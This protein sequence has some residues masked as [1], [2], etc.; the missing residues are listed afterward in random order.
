MLRPRPGT[1]P[2]RLRRPAALFTILAMLVALVTGCGLLG[3]EDDSSSSGGQ[4]EKSKIKLGLLPVVDVASVHLAIREG[5]FKAEGLDVE[6]TNIQ[7]AG[8][9]IPGLIG[10]SLDMVFGNYVSFFAA[11]SGGAAK[12]VDGLKFVADGYIA[13]PNTWMVL[14]GPNSSVNTVRDL[15]GKKVAVTT[16]K[17]LAE[18]SIKSVLRANDVDASKVEFIESPYAGMAA[19]MQQNKVDAALLAEPFITQA[20]KSI[21][22]VPLFDAASGPTADLP[23]AGYGTTGKFAKD[24][25]KTVAAFQRAFAKGQLAAGADRNKIEKLLPEY[26][27]IDPQTAALVALGG[28]PTSL[29][30]TRLQRIPDLMLEFGLLP[31]RF[32][33]SSMILNAGSTK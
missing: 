19:L 30:A 22:A 24:N 11:E 7:G 27:G 14:R 1:P 8:A 28:F 29:E 6:L 21:G 3:G 16:R 32:D 25:P 10:G 9:A 26:A 31:N 18:V 20:Q 12:N 23:I 5:Y 13:K 15:A 2:A 17:S 4:V 33:A